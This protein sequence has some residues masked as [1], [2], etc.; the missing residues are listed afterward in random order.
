[1]Q[2]AW[3]L[4][5]AGRNPIVE[6]SQAPLYT[7]IQLARSPNRIRRQPPTLPS[8]LCSILLDDFSLLFSEYHYTKL[9]SES[10]IL[11]STVLNL[12]LS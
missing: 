1:M 11:C 12:A 2:I 10:A 4:E 6:P 5:A 8:S 7:D 3:G 9:L